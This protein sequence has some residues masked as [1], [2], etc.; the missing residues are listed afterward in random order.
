MKKPLCVALILC[1]GFS[2]IA[3]AAGGGGR[4]AKKLKPRQGRAVIPSA[5]SLI[6]CVLLPF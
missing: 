6:G 1:L 3:M 5:R 2:D 4:M